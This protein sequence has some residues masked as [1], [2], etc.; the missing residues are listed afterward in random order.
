[1]YDA[2]YEQWVEEQAA[3]EKF[4][5]WRKSQATDQ[6]K[7]GWLVLGITEPVRDG[8][9]T[10]GEGTVYVKDENSDQKYPVKDSG[11]RFES[12]DGMVRDTSENKPQFTLMF[13]KGVPYEE[14][15]MTRVADLYHKGGVKYGAR[16]WEKSC[17][18][19]S[20]AK[21]E[22]CLMRHV[23]K[24]LLGMEDED[25]AA[26]VVWN[27]NAVL[28]TRRKIALAEKAKLDAED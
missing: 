21:H 12:S 5:E 19:E 2:D 20:L 18:E 11:K 23:V 16:N 26:A 9:V 14:Q 27:V 1:M 13:P 24:F 7:D 25:H 28:L 22:D 3:L 10:R 6:R 4:Q 15:L 17:T 8:S